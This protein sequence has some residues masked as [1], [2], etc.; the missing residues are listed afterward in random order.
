M[1][2]VIVNDLRKLIPSMPVSSRPSDVKSASSDALSFH[3]H[4]HWEKLQ[5]K[6]PQ[7]VVRPTTTQEIATLARYASD[8]TIPLVPRGGGTGVMG[9]AIPTRGG[10]LIDLRGLNSIEMIS[11]ENHLVV[12]QAG[13]VLESLS[14]SLTGHSLLLGHD[15]WSLPI[16]TVGGAISTN[17]MGYLASKYGS[18]GSQVIG[19][20]IVLP[21]GD[22]LPR[23]TAPNPLALLSNISLLD[24]KDVSASSPEQCSRFFQ[25]LKLNLLTPLCFRVLNMDSKLSGNSN[26]WE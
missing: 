17:G 1:D 20:E 9:A 7:I 21:T 3:D 23:P 8:R 5:I 19:L 16:A 26:L 22:V 2:S 6:T 25:F 11:K 12:V 24:Q 4:H 14:H 13:V 15:P 18:M 10:I